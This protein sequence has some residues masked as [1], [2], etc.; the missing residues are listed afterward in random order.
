VNTI[1]TLSEIG[2]LPVVLD[3]ETAGRMLGIGRTN[4]LRLARTGRFPCRT[5]RVGNL[6]RVPT[7]D[8]LALLGLPVD[9]AHPEPSNKPLRLLPAPAT[10]SFDKDL[11]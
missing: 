2:D 1:P 8:L 9:T 5:V 4:A 10:A 7:A 11:T 6:W 3:I